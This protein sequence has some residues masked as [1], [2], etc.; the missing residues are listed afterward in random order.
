VSLRIERQNA[1]IRCLSKAFGVAGV[2]FERIFASHNT[3]E[4]ESENSAV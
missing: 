3:E 2:L 1:E 4:D